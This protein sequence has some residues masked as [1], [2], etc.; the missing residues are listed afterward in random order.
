MAEGVKV[1]ATNRAARHDYFI[2]E[3]FEAGLV[4]QGTEVKSLRQ[5]RA[6]IGDGYV[7]VDRG[8]AWLENVHIPEYT[9]GTWTNHSPRRK[10]KLLLHAHE[11]DK[12]AIETREKGITIVPLR[13]YFVKGRAKVEIG[14]ARGKKQHDKRHALREKQDTREAQRAMSLRKQ[15]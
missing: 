1:V 2:D 7:A 12:L 9:E 6:T 8:E 15:R 10:R 5:G 13:L 3:T 4:L 11:I 14:I